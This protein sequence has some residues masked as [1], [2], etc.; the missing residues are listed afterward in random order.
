MKE[1]SCRNALDKMDLSSTKVEMFVPRR[2]GGVTDRVG[3]PLRYL[4]DDGICAID[5]FFYRRSE[6]DVTTL[7]VFSDR[8]KTTLDKCVI[9]LEK[10]GSMTHFSTYIKRPKPVTRAC[11]VN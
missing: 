9:S 10:G 3:L 8:A 2:V 11:L 1:D 5:V 7:A 6:G 4:S